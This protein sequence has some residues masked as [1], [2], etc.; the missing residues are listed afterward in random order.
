MTHDSHSKALWMDGCINQLAVHRHLHKIHPQRGTF[1]HFTVTT[2]QN[3]VQQIDRHFIFFNTQSIYMAEMSPA[4]DSD[5][6]V[7]DAYISFICM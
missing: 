1:P 4:S 5:L 7:I 2:Q 6:T 3:D